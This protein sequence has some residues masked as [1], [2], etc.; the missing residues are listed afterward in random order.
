MGAGVRV[1]GAAWAWRWVR[2]NGGAKREGSSSRGGG[3]EERRWNWAD[4][5]AGYSIIMRAC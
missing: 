4:S 1:G 2:G 5:F 3:E